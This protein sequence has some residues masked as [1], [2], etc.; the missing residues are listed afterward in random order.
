M[1]NS[2]PTATAPQPTVRRLES[3]SALKLVALVTTF[4]ELQTVLRCCERLIAALAAEGGAPDDV[5]IESV[6]TVALLS[7]A[8]CFSADGSLTEDDVK[9]AVTAGDGPEWHQLLLTLREHYAAAAAN[10]RERFTVGVV[11]DDNG[12]AGA[13]AITS[14]RQPLVDDVTV[15][16]TGAIAFAL[17]TLVDERITAQQQQVFDEVKDAGRS[18]LDRLPEVEYVEPE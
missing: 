18:V 12:A 11:Q 16:Q 14:S 2:T 3:P 1:L 4:E 7:Y 8:R 10:P 6:W 15:R 9:A 13:V 5:L 17:S